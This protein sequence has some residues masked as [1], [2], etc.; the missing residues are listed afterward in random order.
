MPEFIPEG[1]DVVCSMRNWHVDVNVIPRVV[2]T[3]GVGK[4]LNLA[5][6]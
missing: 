1:E 3:R 4:W 5:M 2:E 6:A